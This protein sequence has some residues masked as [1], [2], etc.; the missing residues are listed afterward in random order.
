VKNAELAR[1]FTDRMCG[2]LFRANPS[3]TQEL[4]VFNML[5]EF[6]AEVAAQQRQ[7]DAEAARNVA[8]AASHPFARDLAPAIGHAVLAT[9]LVG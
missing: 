3:K 9:P 7:A 8:L 6:G 5:V 4:F 1:R 2:Y